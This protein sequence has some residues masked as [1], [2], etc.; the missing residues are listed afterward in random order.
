V[1]SGALYELFKLIL[2]K[3]LR[4]ELGRGETGETSPVDRCILDVDFLEASPRGVSET[5]WV[6]R[7]GALLFRYDE[8]ELSGRSDPE[9]VLGTFKVGPDGLEE[10]VF[11]LGRLYLVDMVNGVAGF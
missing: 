3:N 7:V 1:S 8:A 6:D 5:K 10:L 2:E 4:I 9:S 11:A